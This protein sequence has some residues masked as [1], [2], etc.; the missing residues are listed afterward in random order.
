LQIAAAELGV[1]ES[2]V[3]HQVKRLSEAVGQQLL[4]ESGRSIALT[5]VGESLGNKLA[6]AFPHLDSLIRE[7][8]GRGQQSLRLAVCSV[9]GRGWLI[10]RPPDF[11]EAHP[12]VALELKLYAQ[13]PL[14]THV[15]ADAFVVADE[16]KAGCVAI[17]LKEEKLLAVEAR[18]KK[19]SR[20]PA[21]RHRLITTDFQPGLIG[22]DWKDS[23]RLARMELQDL[24]H[25]TFLTCS[26]YMVALEMAKRGHGVALEPDF[27]AARD[28]DAGALL[29]FSDALLPSGRT[30]HLCFM[31]TRAHEAK[32]RFLVHWFRSKAAETPAP[33]RNHQPMTVH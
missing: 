20:L 27:L 29:R 6:C 5:P 11:Y 33:A 22:E 25:G 10:E 14:V 26:H 30:Y 16:L 3:S 28:I 17:P 12:E 21:G 23:F 31:K 2:A 9:F 7:L 13:N 1:T 32:L 8:V 24:Q 4:V 19:Q 18:R 15:V